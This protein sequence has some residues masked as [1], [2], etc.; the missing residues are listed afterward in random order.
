VDAQKSDRLPW[1]DKPYVNAEAATTKAISAAQRVRTNPKSPGVA[2]WARKA[3]DAEIALL[4]GTPKGGGPQGGRNGQ[5]FLSTANLFEIVASG[6]LDGASV[7]NALR[8]AMRTNGYEQDKGETDVTATF[9]SGRRRGLDNP[10]DLSRVATRS[11]GYVRSSA[12]DVPEPIDL[13]SVFALEQGFW[14]QRESLQNVYLGALSRMCSPWAVLGFCVARALATVR[15]NINLPPIVAGP[16]SLNWFCAL[17]AQSGGGKSGALTVAKEL[18]ETYV[19]TRNLGSGEG[20]IDAY[21]KPGNKETGEPPGQYE[22]MMFVVDEGDMLRALNSRTGSSLS[23]NLRS[24]FTGETLG[25]SNRTAS[26]MH[27]EAQTYRMTLV[28]NIQP[29]RA[30]T[31]LDDIHGGT[32][33]RFMWFPGVDVRITAEVPLMPAALTLPSPG[34]WQ[35]PNELQIPYEAVALIRDERVRLMRGEKDC[36]DGHALFIREKF[37][38]ALA[39]LDG[40]DQMTLEDWRLAGIASRVSDRTREW[41]AEQLKESEQDEDDKVGRRK[42]AQQGAA[43]EEKSARSTDKFN[44]VYNRILGKIKAS[45]VSGVTR[46]ELNTLI[47]GR[48]RKAYLQP[49]LD[50]LQRN[51]LVEQVKDKRDKRIERWIGTND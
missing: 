35:Y 50:A 2:S 18:V 40:R 37:A 46:V 11:G 12:D 36:L 4:A 33:Q 10:R 3:L 7:E 30:G 6:A 19:L 17:A 9:N 22:S 31:L 47:A 43:D 24:A 1:E 44:S 13:S 15:P 41:V 29:A 48:D 14:T 23:P 25:A 32:L 16:G 34:A 49:A 51:Q 45:G 38:F 20:L 26:S 21:A 28:C 8:D 39:V 5:L 27:L 42:G